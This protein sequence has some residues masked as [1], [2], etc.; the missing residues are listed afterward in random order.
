M[1]HQ[2]LNGLLVVERAEI[3]VVFPVRIHADKLLIRERGDFYRLVGG[4][5]VHV[6]DMRVMLHQDIQNRGVDKSI[7][8]LCQE[9]QGPAFVHG[10]VF[11]GLD[12]LFNDGCRGHTRSRFKTISVPSPRATASRMPETA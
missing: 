5:P 12:C 11:L 9:R 6:G 10:G 1:S 8:L 7:V 2:G 3:D 4:N